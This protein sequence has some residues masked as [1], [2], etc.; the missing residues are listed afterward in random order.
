MKGALFEAG[1]ERNL[2]PLPNNFLIFL[3]VV[4]GFLFSFAGWP[5]VTYVIEDLGRRVATLFKRV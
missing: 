2:M 4:V 3:A 1:S 5:F